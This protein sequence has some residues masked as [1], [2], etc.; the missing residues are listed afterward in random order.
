MRKLRHREEKHPDQVHATEP[1]WNLGHVNQK[2][3]GS[4][5]QSQLSGCWFDPGVSKEHVWIGGGA[6]PCAQMRMEQG[7]GA[8]RDSPSLTEGTRPPG[9]Q[10]KVLPE[11]KDIKDRR[12]WSGVK[13]R[14]P[15]RGRQPS[16]RLT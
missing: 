1:V 4:E 14:S 13:L 11:H 8:G 6:P 3:K 2:L 7:R 10:S 12:G 15:Q 16:L 9:L 5:T